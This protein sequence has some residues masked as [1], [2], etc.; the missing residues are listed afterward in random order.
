MKVLKTIILTLGILGSIFY[1]FTCLTPYINPSHSYFLSFASLLFP[2]GLVVMLC[3]CIISHLFF[4]KLSWI[5]IVVF[6]MGYKNISAVFGFHIDNH[7]VQSKS[8]KNIRILS[9]NVNNFLSG[10]GIDSIKVN[11]MLEYISLSNADILCF[12]DYSSVPYKQAN[13]STENIKKI[14]GLP[15]SFFCEANKNYGV[16]IFSRWPFIKAT[17]IP[18]SNI[19]SLESLQMVDI[20]TPT[21]VL[22]V[23]N[24]H[25]SSMNI[26]VPILNNDNIQHLKFINYDTAILMHRDKLSR[27]AYFDKLHSIQA[28]LVK[29][30]LDSSKIP[31]IYTADMNAVPSSYVYHHIRSGLNDAFLE[32]GWGFGRTYDSLSPTLRID[33]ILTSPSIKTIQYNCTRIHLSDHLPIITDI[34]FKP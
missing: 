1:L 8:S 23:F 34:Q 18:Y 11:Q 17:S 6:L 22:R 27:L 21:K 32:K 29:K 3:W 19:N 30:S 15:Y 13:A 26:H 5:F 12:Q 33:V 28:E 2:V 25:L 16:I 20:Q 14:T 10:R 7:F 24:T 4:R 9:W 31:F